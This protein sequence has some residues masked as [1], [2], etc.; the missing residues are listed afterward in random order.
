MSIKNWMGQEIEEGSYVYR[1]ARDGNSSSYK[2]GKVLYLTPEKGTARVEWLYYPSSKWVQTG[3]DR[4][5]G[6]WID[7]IGKD[8]NSSKGSPSINSLILISQAD[9]GWLEHLFQN[10]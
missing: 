6:H 2:V 9:F 7:V 8:Q 1:G 5:D 3:T 4:R 10:Q